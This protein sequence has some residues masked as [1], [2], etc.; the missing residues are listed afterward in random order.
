[1]TAGTAA[2]LRPTDSPN[3]AV[4][5]RLPFKPRP[6]TRSERNHRHIFVFRSPR[7]DRVVTVAEHLHLAIALRF[8]FDPSLVAYVERPRRIALKERQEIDISF[9]TRNRQGEECFY[10]AI[11]QSGTMGCTSGTVAV[12]DRA[13][14][15]LAAQRHGIV[16]NY[17][18]EQEMIAAMGQCATALD[19]LPHVWAHEHLLTRS[20]IR[21]Q[22]SAWFRQTPRASLTQ[23]LQA[24]SF[25]A[26]SVRAVVAAMVHDG[27]LALVDY[28]PG[29]S[30]AVLEVRHA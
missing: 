7:N 27:S 14:L 12:R 25:D 21:S 28:K 1:M 8:E 20:G 18:T 13:A 22:I 19:L 2:T 17:I 9:W 24:L 3:H 23:L 16:L 5:S 29:A 26:C 4:N 30:D 11:P 15:D 10:L 6:L